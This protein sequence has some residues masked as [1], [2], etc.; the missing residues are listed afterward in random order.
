MG[1]FD[2]YVDPQPFNGGGSLSRLLVLQQFPGQYQPGPDFD[3]PPAVS[4]T[5]SA[6]MPLPF[7]YGRGLQS[8]DRLPADGATTG[9]PTKFRGDQWRRTRWVS[10]PSARAQNTFD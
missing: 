3:Q 10:A 1:L 8:Q 5:W 7:G 6:S 9:E 2:G 4:Q